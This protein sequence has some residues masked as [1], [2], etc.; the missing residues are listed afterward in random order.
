MEDGGVTQDKRQSAIRPEPKNKLSETERQS[1][2]NICNE[3][4]YADLPPSQIVPRLAD[5]GQYIASESSFYR[6]LKAHNQLAHRGR[7]KPKNGTKKPK[8]YT[9]TGPNEVWSWDITYCPATVIGRYYYLYMIEDIFSRKIVGWE[10]HESEQGEH[11]AALLERSVWSEKCVRKSL[12]LHSDNG[13][14]MKSLTMQAKMQDLGVASSRSRPGVSND[15]PFSESLFRTLKYC[16]RWPSE[17]FKSIDEART[18]VKEFV[19]WYNTEHRH[20]R[21]NFVTPEQRHLGL[22]EE[23]LSKRDELYRKM[24]RKNQIRWSKA[25]RNW[26]KVGDVKLNPEKEKQAA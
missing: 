11:A 1:I 19:T 23:I 12:V 10:V 18:W 4:E 14:P 3:P 26:E 2:I 13:S 17:G 6:V 9:A 22:D 21:I 24:K 25:T 15:N 8:G 7:D 20:S 16:R 5:K